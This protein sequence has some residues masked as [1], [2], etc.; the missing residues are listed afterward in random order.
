MRDKLIGFVL[1]VLLGISMVMLAMEARSPQSYA[2]DASAAVSIC[3]PEVSTC[4]TVT[5]PEKTI[6]LPGRTIT[7]PPNPATVTRMLPRP[8]R[9]TRTVTKRLPQRTVTR[10]VRPS[11]TT[12]NRSGTGAPTKTVTISERRTATPGGQITVTSATIVPTT[13]TVRLPGTTIQVETLKKVGLGL[14][15]AIIMITLILAAMY[16][17][18]MSGLRAGERR[19]QDEDVKFIQSLKD[20]FVTRGRHR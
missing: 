18:W 13:K 16:F 2:V 14:L 1:T 20:S 5:L 3:P 8:P 4:V 9:A 15:S 10:I 12:I 11:E 6:T 17:A 7:V 19:H